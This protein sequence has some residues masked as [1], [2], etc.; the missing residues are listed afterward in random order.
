[1]RGA[2]AE[3]KTDSAGMAAAPGV[4]AFILRLNVVCHAAGV[5]KHAAVQRN[6]CRAENVTGALH[7]TGPT[8]GGD[9]IHFHAAVA[10]GPSIEEIVLVKFLA[11]HQCGFGSVG[12]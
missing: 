2:I 8:P 12:N 5:V 10:A 6:G 9:L 7:T 1:M 3:H 11:H 4:V